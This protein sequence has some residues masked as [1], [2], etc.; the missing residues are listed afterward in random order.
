MGIGELVSSP[1]WVLA[2]GAA[3]ALGLLLTQAGIVLA[4]RFRLYAEPNARSSHAVP[5]PQ[6]GGLGPAVPTLAW[7]FFVVLAAPH[8][9]TGAHVFFYFFFGS[10]LL[11]F[12]I[13]LWD[14]LTSLSPKRKLL[15]Q[16]VAAALAAEVLATVSLALSG[17][18]GAAL[19]ASQGLAAA[20]W[21][22]WVV[23]FV[24]TFNFMDGMNGK[25]GLFTLNA[26][27]FSLVMMA[28]ALPG[29]P[30]ESWFTKITQVPTTDLLLPIGITIGGVAGFLVFNLRPVA[31]VFLGDGGSHFLGCFLATVAIATSA[32][33]F[34]PGLSMLAFVILLFPFIYDVVVTLARRTVAR[35][36]LWEAHREHLYQ[37]LLI[38]GRSHMRVLAVCSLTYVLCGLLA[39]GCVRAH[40]L[41]GRMGCLA[42]AVAVMAGYTVFVLHAERRARATAGVAAADRSAR[43]TAP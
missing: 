7:L 21:L 31:R 5:T 39:V 20:V 19:L 28:V 16:C 40:S 41:P 30:G 34:G 22:V 11:F 18:H 17:A 43:S 33:L 36:P 15:A 14:D 12:A 24:N 29:G 2:V 42:G 1:T 4:H 23:A 32:S 10:S 9:E 8:M 25:A 27:L 35:K 26:L 38:A 37:R 13:G 3:F 6:L